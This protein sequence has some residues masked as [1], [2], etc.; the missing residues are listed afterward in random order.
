MK[1]YILAIDT[2]SYSGNFEREMSGWIMGHDYYNEFYD[3]GKSK[4]SRDRHPELTEYTLWKD[5][6]TSFEFDSEYGEQACGIVETP[7]YSNNGTGKHT[8]IA[9]GEKRVWPAY[10]SVGIAVSEPAKLTGEFFDTIKM[11][12]TEFATEN[13]IKIHN[14]R[15]MTIETTTVITESELDSTTEPVL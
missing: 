11:M 15:L 3:R 6:C 4:E 14:Y 10:Q 13:N 1:N 12:A 9:L 8:K 7:G 2:D 5:L